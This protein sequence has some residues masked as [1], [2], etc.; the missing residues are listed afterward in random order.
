MKQLIV[1]G[2]FRSTSTGLFSSSLNLRKETNE[3]NRGPLARTGSEASSRKK[4]SDDPSCPRSSRYEDENHAPAAIVEPYAA[5]EIREEPPPP[6]FERS[7]PPRPPS[8]AGHHHPLPK[9]PCTAGRRPR[10]WPR[11]VSDSLLPSS[12]ARSSPSPTRSGGE[13]ARPCHSGGRYGQICPG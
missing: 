9:Q 1:S 3:K 10:A 11:W 2:F 6:R 5:A 7:W 4:I 13:R 12:K 8:P